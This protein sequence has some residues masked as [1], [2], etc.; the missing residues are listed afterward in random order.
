MDTTIGAPHDLHADL[1]IGFVTVEIPEE[2]REDKGGNLAIPILGIEPLMPAPHRVTEAITY[3]ATLIHQL[4]ECVFYPLL[5]CLILVRPMQHTEKNV[6]KNFFIRGIEP[7]P[8]HQ[9]S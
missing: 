6:E 7:A 5:K 3:S 8:T 9:M 2:S 4:T 1:V